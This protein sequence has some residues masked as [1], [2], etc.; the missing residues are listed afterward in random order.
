VKEIVFL[1][2]EAQRD[3]RIDMY[4]ASVMV[5]SRS[6]VQQL[7]K[8]KQ[9]TVNGRVVKANHRLMG[10]ERIVVT[11][12]APV[13]LAVE[14][15]NIELPILY[16]DKDIIVINKPRGMVVHPAL[17]NYTGTL[18]NALLYHCKND[19]SG[20]NGVIR[21][22]IVHRLDK[23]T[24]GVMVAAKNDAAHMG[25]AEQIKTHSAQRTYWTIVHG[26]IAEERGTV[27]APIG[28]HQKERTKMAVAFRN[29][30]DAITHFEVLERFGRYTLLACKLETGRTHQIRVHMAYIEHPVVND[31]LY[32]RRNQEFPI[33]GQALH[34][35]TLELQHPITGEHMHFE[36]PLPTD[37][38]DCIAYAK[39][40]R[41]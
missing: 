2:A 23:D 24:S 32:G 10:Q 18:V 38:Q 39:E 27:D 30:R 33:I 14:A 7:L 12:A 9:V 21:P 35:A 1:T 36:A 15:E 4:L 8:E 22:G 20:I 5:L 29:S 28:R 40:H 26:N 6:F 17:G 11:M 25:L 3:E 37:F 41:Q 19:L 13:A 16:E 31:P 34:S